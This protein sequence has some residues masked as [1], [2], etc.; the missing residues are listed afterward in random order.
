MQKVVITDK[1]YELEQAINRCLQSPTSRTTDLSAA[2]VNSASAA[3]SADPSAA[4]PAAIA[5][6]A[7]P[8]LDSDSKV[9]AAIA[10]A[11]AAATIETDS[12]LDAKQKASPAQIDSAH[13][14]N[15]G[16]DIKI[17]SILA[18]DPVSISDPPATVE[19]P[20]TAS[21]D[22]DLEAAKRLSLQDAQRV[23]SA[24][25]EKAVANSLLEIKGSSIGT[26]ANMVDLAGP[27]RSNS[28]FDETQMKK[29]IEASIKMARAPKSGFVDPENP[30]QS[31]RL[32]G[33]PVGLRNNGNI[34]YFNSIVQVLY[35]AYPALRRAILAFPSNADPDE[36]GKCELLSSN[37]KRHETRTPEHR[38]KTDVGPV[39]KPLNRVQSI[40]L[41]RSSSSSTDSSQDALVESRRI[42]IPSSPATPKKASSTPS[43]PFPKVNPKANRE[44]LAIAFV[45]QLQR[46]FAY[47]KHSLRR[48]FDPKAAVAALLRFVESKGGATEQNAQHDVA[49]FF[50]AV[51]DAMELAFKARSYGDVDI[52]KLFYG[53]CEERIEPVASGGGVVETAGPATEPSAVVSPSPKEI[54]VGEI[55]VDVAPAKL[56]SALSSYMRSTIDEF[57][58]PGGGSM[59]ATK[60]LWFKRFP[61]IL[62]IQIQRLGFDQVKKRAKKFNL[63]FH[64]PKRLHMGRYLLAN[65][66]EAHRLRS[67][68][69][70]LE[71][72]LKSLASRL[73]GYANA[74]CGTD[75]VGP[76][77]DLAIQASLV[78]VNKMQKSVP[79]SSLG[80]TAQGLRLALARARQEMS[81]LENQRKKVEKRLETLYE[82]LERKSGGVGEYHLSG[83]MVHEGADATQG[84]YWAYVDIGTGD[85]AAKEEQGGAD[86]RHGG[87][88]KEEVSGGLVA[89]GKGHEGENR[90][91][92]RVDMD[93]ATPAASDTTNGEATG[94]RWV[95]FND[96]SVTVE[97]EEIV[98]KESY[99]GHKNTSGYFLVYTAAPRAAQNLGGAVPP[100]AGS[101]SCSPFCMEVKACNK[102]FLSEVERWIR[103][104]PKA[105][106]L[107]EQANSM[108]T[109]GKFG[110]K[111]GSKEDPAPKRAKTSPSSV[112]GLAVSAAPMT[113]SD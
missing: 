9:S 71:A 77:L 10:K 47:L 20:T 21:I 83:V 81:D 15:D 106:G 7:T 76:R 17:D 13:A 110:Q 74:E 55:I 62:C 12:T 101:C 52:E 87:S 44:A 30:L 50:Q 89:R 96:A 107:A 112:D 103:D 51:I 94:S 104:H 82:A 70:E 67:R 95:R 108:A 69:S 14:V 68:R 29:A 41:S 39:C 100:A 2:A 19:T 85:S 5:M 98:F 28:G 57:K 72:R 37:A 38:A 84:H 73:A 78:Y 105:S 113:L 4:S 97:Q 66:E 6:E 25:V 26:H 8:S 91:R 92:K 61:K 54:V 22:A 59:P 48:Y 34:C 90:K 27:A 111:E 11:A 23:E 1:V 58:L 31:K 75:E 42:P 109:D 49:E 18:R 24:T 99:G 65:R 102:D 3:S 79:D 36:S 63:P 88:K 60:S 80:A 40:T 43:Q 86:R 93:V 33:M 32:A 16:A 53:V 45:V 35:C 46:T 56:H 64:F